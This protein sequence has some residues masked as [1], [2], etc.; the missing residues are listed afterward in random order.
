MKKQVVILLFIILSIFCFTPIHSNAL[1]VDSNRFYK[2]VGEASDSTDTDDLMNGYD[3]DQNCDGN[4]S[5]LG[6]PNDE[7]SVAWLLQQVFNFIK[8]V[9]PILVVILSSVD[10][11]KV[12]FTGNDDAMGK[13]QKK[14]AIRLVLAASLFFIPTIVAALL[15]IFGLTSPT[16]GIR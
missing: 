3:Q 2:L 14:L 12:V 11:A 6:D 7:N 10:F 16:C 5:L 13:A 15:D 8:V 9:G 1:S 4:D